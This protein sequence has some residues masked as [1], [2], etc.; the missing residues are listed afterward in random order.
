MA[1]SDRARPGDGERRGDGAAGWAVRRVAE[2]RA[3]RP[4]RAGGGA[5]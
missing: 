4:V 3:A 1:G 2:Q 5:G